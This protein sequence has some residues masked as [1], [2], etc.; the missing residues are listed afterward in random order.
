[1]FSI[2]TYLQEKYSITALSTNTIATG[3]P[4]H[5]F[6]SWFLFEKAIA[7]CLHAIIPMFSFSFF[8][9]I[10]QKGNTKDEAQLAQ[11]LDLYLPYFQEMCG[12]TATA[13]DI[14]AQQKPTYR[15]SG[16]RNF[17]LALVFLALF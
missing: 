15:Y 2:Y 4:C 16:R 9:I 6:W 7:S 1:M 3:L 8:Y 13:P 12:V 10:K 5:L 11:F 17:F 14:G